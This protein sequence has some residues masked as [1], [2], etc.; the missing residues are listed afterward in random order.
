METSDE[1][2]FR[3]SR[4][5]A[6][7][8]LHRREREL[9]NRIAGFVS[10][11]M[12]D[13]RWVIHPRPGIPFGAVGYP[14]VA[15]N[16]L[17]PAQLGHS[18]SLASDIAGFLL[19]LHGIEPLA[20]GLS[21][22]DVENAGRPIVRELHRSVAA[23]LR[24]EFGGQAV[25]RIKRWLDSVLADEKLLQP[26]PRLRHGDFWYGNLLID[27][28]S[29]ALAAVLDFENA[30][31]GDPALDFATLRYIGDDFA[32]TV[33][34]LYVASGGAVDDNF[35]HRIQRHWELREFDG[36]SHV[37]LND[38]SDE[39]PDQLRKLRDGPVMSTQPRFQDVEPHSISRGSA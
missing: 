19:E 7:M 13:P 23:V 9:L 37:V 20:V 26:T 10:V 11:S 22:R 35:A 36:L 3:L 6:S 5:P 16:P 28:A 30:G 34:D 21:A 14:K 25:E 4:S 31:I 2:V 38:L 24:Q 15:G 18:K 39:L 12:P 27:P 17:N 33:L 1:I 32:R 29:G 8:L